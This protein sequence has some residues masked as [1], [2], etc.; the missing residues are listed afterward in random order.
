MPIH[1]EEEYLA[2][3]SG[4]LH[5]GNDKDSRAGDTL[6]VFGRQIKHN[7]S[8]GF[9]LLTTK[10]V[11]FK[12]VITELLWILQG[13]TDLKYLHEHGLKYW[14]PD[15]ERSGRT[16]GTL[17]P[18][19][20]SQLRNFNGVDQL[21]QLLEQI[22]M[23][24]SS[25]RIMASFWNPSVMD[26]VVLPPCHYGFQLYINNGKMDLMWNQRSVDVFLGLPYDIG[27]YGLL[28][29]ML[30]QGTEYVPGKLVANLG[31][32]H[33][34]KEHIPQAKEQLTREMR[35]LPNV[36]V[37]FGLSRGIPEHKHIHIGG[38]D[39]NPPIK[40]KLLVG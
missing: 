6:S 18:V 8:L 36:S 3:M 34:Y 14:D 24:P 15:Y 37:D 22:K 19:Y 39:P 23:E 35:S 4:I 16:D 11:Y 32:C 9:P 40:A 20:G 12:H 29:I 30:C 5:G 2:L 26:N 25:R 7:M 31:D 21:K 27:M 33:L 13:R 1:I 17:G 28:L 38:Y 10:R